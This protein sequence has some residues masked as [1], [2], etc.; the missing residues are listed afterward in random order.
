MGGKSIVKHQQHVALRITPH[1]RTLRKA[2]E[3]IRWMVIDGLSAR[4]I[5]NYFARWLR[6]WVRTSTTWDFKELVEQFI[7]QCWQEVPAAIAADVLRN[8]ITELNTRACSDDSNR[9]T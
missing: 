8:Y 3:N 6:W 9:A 2:R 7:S 5:R 1:A 4:K